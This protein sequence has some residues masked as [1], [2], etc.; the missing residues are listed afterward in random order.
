MKWAIG[1]VSW[2]SRVGIDKAMRRGRS[3]NRAMEGQTTS[4][5][6]HPTALDK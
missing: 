4:L 1:E 6:T 2:K 3:P 5:S